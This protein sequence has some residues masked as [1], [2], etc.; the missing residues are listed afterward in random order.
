MSHTETIKIRNIRI[1][2]LLLFEV[3]FV[4]RGEVHCEYL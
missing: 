1:S 4:F 2:F 3:R